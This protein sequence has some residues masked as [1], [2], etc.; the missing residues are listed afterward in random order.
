MAEKKPAPR[1]SHVTYASFRNDSGSGGWKVGPTTR[2]D[3]ADEQLVTEH[4]P[5][6][7]LPTRAFDDFIGAAEI[8]DLPR[9]LEYIPLGD[10]G[11]LMQSVPAG[12]DATGRPG[13]VFTHA[14]I[15]HDLTRPWEAI[16]PINV[17]RSKDLLTPFRMAS[18][19]AVELAPDVG[20]PRMGPLA[21]L[22]VAWMM[23]DGMLGDRRGALYR[24]QDVLSEGTHQPVVVAKNSN[25]AAYW[26][27][28]LSST[29][30]PVEAR[31]LLRFSTFERAGS[32]PAAGPATA[33]A[34]IVVPVEDKEEFRRREGVRVIDPADPQTHAT[35]PASAWS[36]LT[37]AV[38]DAETSATAVVERLTAVT[39]KIDEDQL[40]DL[41]FGIGLALLVDD[42]P[43]TFGADLAN[44]ARTHVQAWRSTPTDNDVALVKRVIDH[45]EQA[46]RV[47]AWPVMK[48]GEITE[49][50]YFQLVDAGLA[51]VQKLRDADAETLVAYL[52][53]LLRTGLLP[54]ENIQD[55]GV[56]ST[57][58][59]FPAMERWRDAPPPAGAHAELGA[60]LKLAE[61]D[62]RPAA[63]AS[64]DAGKRTPALST[65]EQLL[66]DMA[67]AKNVRSVMLWL[68][69][70]EAVGKLRRITEKQVVERSEHDHVLG[71]LRAYYTVV[72]LCNMRPV[73]SG[74]RRRDKWVADAL[75][76]LALKAVYRHVS[77]PG[78]ALGKFRRLG[79]QIALADLPKVLE[80]R[81]LER[82]AH[83]HFVEHS[84]PVNLKIS[85]PPGFQDQHTP[86]VAAVFAAVAQGILEKVDT[87]E[88]S[89][90]DA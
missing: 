57:F 20:E 49:R 32:L 45:P 37:Q 51:S 63:T 25:E 31:R 10:R 69:R 90:T 59:A 77:G 48:P 84:D 23:V 18:V 89:I 73:L 24:I 22:T 38:F 14:V 13:N 65:D 41:T 55:P 56:R 76:A 1:W 16:Y 60:L 15:D 70:E 35:S 54:R 81:G 85:P 75:S 52:D 6:S 3:Q 11:L 7:V 80:D 5:T 62:R 74:D 26:L 21:D 30:S 36:R 86:A 64:R 50:R 39:A 42:S 47:A 8:E 17:Y 87:S 28:A 61:K 72:V 71:L 82:E 34:V 12:K 2:A 9:R 44:L 19:N 27:Q 67:R 79:W 83:G 53:F 46:R 4:A 58:S 78:V 88:R 40:T 43:A 29:L 66:W 33:G 68:G